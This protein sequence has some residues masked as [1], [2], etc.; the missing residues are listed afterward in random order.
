MKRSQELIQEESKYFAP[1]GRI[2]YYPLV[3][4]HAHGSTLTDV[5]G[6]E[7]LDLLTSASAL[8]VGHTPEP[9]VN[10]IIAQVKKMIH[11]TPAY[12]YHEPLMHLAK[13]MCE[14][15]PGD[16]EKRVIFGLTGSDANDALIKFARG[17]TGRPYIISF[18]NAYHGST[19][20]SISMSAISQNMRRKI[21]PLLPGFYHIPF[22][23]SY[24]GMYG[25]AEPNTVEEYLA[26]L[27]EMLA[28]YVPPEEVAA[29]VIETLQGDGG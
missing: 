6:N 21:G 17:Y 29:V 9:I 14:I 4:D 11:Y 23:D 2:P 26:P 5:D 27:K 3:I 22:P 19:Y 16:F 7:Y 24:R 28:T 10:A 8:N 1:A 12:M 18:V 13:K 20:G 15:T 25:S